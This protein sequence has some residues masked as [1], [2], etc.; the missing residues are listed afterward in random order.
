MA[1]LEEDTETFDAQLGRIHL[2]TS[3]STA[4]ELASFL[5]IHPSEIAKA[6]RRGKI[7]AEWLVVMMMSESILPEWILTGRG[8][9]CTLDVWDSAQ[10]PIGEEMAVQQ[11]DRE[12]L[13]RLPSTALAKEL[14][15][16]IAVGRINASAG[17]RDGTNEPE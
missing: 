17:W 7:P 9:C 1:Y 13:R 12:A 6:R 2:I 10:R 4:E 11:A 14:V 3:T 5:D 16:R 15:R 8:P